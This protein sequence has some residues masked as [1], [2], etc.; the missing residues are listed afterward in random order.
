MM[1]QD[2]QIKCETSVKC[3]DT[4]DEID[5]DSSDEFYKEPSILNLDI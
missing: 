2:T 1:D 4:K 3:E 5:S